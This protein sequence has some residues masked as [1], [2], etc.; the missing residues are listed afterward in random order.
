VAQFAVL[1]TY[2]EIIKKE[3]SLAELQ[4]V[5]GK[6]RRREVIFLLAKLNC[7]LG[8]W[9]NAPQFDLDARFSD[10][11]LS[12]FRQDLERMR[13][14]NNSRVVFS[15]LGILYLMKQACVAC[16]ENGQLLNTRSA[17]SDLGVCFL[18][19][20]DLLLPFVPSPSDGILERMANILPFADY[21][22][23]D[24]YPMEVGR[25]QFI[26]DEIAKLPSLVARTDFIDLPAL[27][28][29]HFEFDQGT[30]CE[31]VFGCA[32]RFL[33]PKLEDL[34]SDPEMA[35]L[36][37]T[38]FGKSLIPVDT[39]AR[40]FTN[41]TVTESVF[42]ENV[43]ASKS[44]PGDDLTIF[45]AFPLIEI[46]KDI[47]VCL[48]PGFLM[49]KAGRGLYWSLFGKV[50]DD[51]RGKLATFWGA[52]FESYVNYI[53][54]RSYSVGGTFIPEPTFANG[55]AAFDA[56][57]VEGRNLLVLEHKSSAIR[58]DAKYGGDTAKLKKEL[59][60]KF[61][62]GDAEGAKGLAQLSK[63]LVRFL[64][65]DKLSGITADEI[66]RVYP[67][68]VC[69]ESTMVTPYMG[70]YLNE[71]FADIYPR[72]QFHQVV[73]PV[74]T[75]EMADVENLLGYLQ[76]F[77]FSDIFES[78]HSK[79][80]TMLT[81]LSSSD[82]PLLKSAKPKTN[83]VREGFTRFSELMA[84]DLFGETLAKPDDS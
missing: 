5:L 76:S 67:V 54:Q 13:H 47:Y 16:P 59:D 23:H 32:S 38:Y 77:A 60:L 1:I 28:Q 66:D 48:D 63:H 34:E 84:A 12:D 37:S 50:Q 18:I 19:V 44:R 80:K 75:L 74:F 26:F 11:L 36:R 64:T 21:I 14:P 15:R 10:Y 30:F 58:A 22:S 24:H 29:E 68:M 82:V 71:R 49:D 70:R 8:T 41:L 46:V 31:L 6:Y 83:I 17:H 52:V 25:T 72:K 65:G 33:N 20:N 45:Q 57:L 69:L 42:V 27:F 3:P 7:L 2:R 55:D 81:S 43:K 61:I 73:T 40:F 35:V 78:Y 62:E 53:L 56:C 79:N 39:I 9:Q 4:A 51:Q